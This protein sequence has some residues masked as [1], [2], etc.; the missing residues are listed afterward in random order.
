MKKPEWPGIATA[1]GVI[2]IVTIVFAA[3]EPDFKLKDWQPLMAAIIALG[4]AA[5]AYRAAIAKVDFDRET[6]ERDR[7]SRKLGVFSRLLL[8]LKVL[9]IE[10]KHAARTIDEFILSDSSDKKITHFELQLTE[11]IELTET[12]EKIDMFPEAAINGIY[13]VRNLLPRMK[14][15]LDERIPGSDITG[16]DSDT[17]QFLKDYKRACGDLSRAIANIAQSIETERT[18]F[19]RYD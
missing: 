10:A 7:I 15:D 19:K 8:A 14:A 1:V 6:A 11:I 2:L 18:R 3:R 13:T 17:D 5:L 16:A 12:W 4:A 9:D